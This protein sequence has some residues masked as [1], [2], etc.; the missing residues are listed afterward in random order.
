M[1]WILAFVLVAAA[2]VYAGSKLSRCADQLANRFGLSRSWVG[3]LL[4]SIVTTLPEGATTISSIA[5]VGS[6][7]LALGNNF[8]SILFNVTIIA[9]CAVLFRRQGV[10]RNASPKNAYPAACAIIMIALAMLAITFPIP[11]AAFGLRFGLGTVVILAMFVVLFACMQRFESEQLRVDEAKPPHA[12]ADLSTACVVAGFSAAAVAVVF[13]GFGLAVTGDRLAKI[14]GL[15]DSFVGMLFLAFATSLP[16]LIVGITAVRIGAYDLMLGNVMGANMI[17][18]LVIAVA[19]LVYVKDVL[20]V[21]GNLGRENTF[22]GLFSVLETCVV[23]LG[24]LSASKNK[25]HRR[26]E[27]HAVL[28]FMLYLTC[29]GAMFFGKTLFR[30]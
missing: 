29:L 1:I 15:T 13:C 6:P 23:I 8:G 16:E 12:A 25:P 27:P 24:C 4:V 18:V 3:L 28:L 7:D 19:D 21:P 5:K 10:L 26:V 11:I 14:L 17:N 20:Q 2:I 22:A 30:P 9:I